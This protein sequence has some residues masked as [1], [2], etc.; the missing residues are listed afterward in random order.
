MTRRESMERRRRKQRIRRIRRI[1]KTVIIAA[2]CLA[3]F[4]VA[5]FIVRAI[6]GRSAETVA[7]EPSPV[8]VKEAEAEPSN[9]TATT[10]ALERDG[11]TGWNVDET[12]WWYRNEDGTSYVNG[13]QTLDGISYYFTSDGYIGTGW[14]DT[15]SNYQFFTESGILKPNEKQKRIALTYDDGPSSHTEKIIDVLEQYHCKA[16][17]FVVGE[18]LK[19]GDSFVEAL[20]REGSSGMEIGSHTY[21]HT[22]LTNV[23][24]ESIYKTMNEN[25]AVISETT[26]ITPVVMRPPGGAVND[27]VK[28]NVTKPMIMWDVD[29][30][31]WETRNAD[32]TVQNIRN[33]VREGSVILMHDLY[34][35][36]A[37]ATEKIVPELIAQGY[38]PVTVS[39]LAEYYGYDMNGGQVY[40]AFY[41]ESEMADAEIPDDEDFAYSYDIDA[42][43]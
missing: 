30:R 33:E 32:S 35:A 42:V 24:A 5:F 9:D 39:E 7:N 17:F 20:K 3:V 37:E 2:I 11:N 15:G 1:I 28:A 19:N 18:M 29:T 23:D 14:V 8:V 13:W 38:L 12:G 36:T 43:G 10:A 25:D 6:R 41:P 34:E 21:D 27:S 4:F 31:D 22:I 40:H 26:G 16:T